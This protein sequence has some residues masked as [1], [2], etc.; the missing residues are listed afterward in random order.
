MGQSIGKEF[1]LML[2][3]K[4]VRDQTRG[5][6]VHLDIQ[7]LLTVFGVE[8]FHVSC[9]TRAIPDVPFSPDIR[10]ILS[11]NVV[12]ALSRVGRVSITHTIAHQRRNSLL[13][14]TIKSHLG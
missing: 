7:I 11:V 12:D 9:K 2:S 4:A 3:K 8:W 10:P 14:E 13:L 5:P 1:L 6:S